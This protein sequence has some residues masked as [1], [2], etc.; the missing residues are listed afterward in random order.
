MIY[1]KTK[2]ICTI[3]PAVESVEKICELIDAG[4]DAARLNFSHG[5]HKIH[6]KY[7][8]NIREAAKLKGK[9]IA[10]IQD[11]PG[12]KIRV[13]RL[14][15]GYIDLV[16][17]WD[18]TIT[19]KEVIGNDQI[20][21]TNY[22]GLINDLD[23]GESILLDDGNLK[24]K[25]T[26]LDKENGEAVCEIINGGILKE[27]KGINLPETKLNLNPLTEKDLEHLRFGLENG[28]DFIAMSFVRV[29]E[30]ITHLRDLLRSDNIDKPII[31]KI[32]RPEAVENIDSIIEVS[33]VIMVARGDMGVEISTEEVP[34]IQKLIINKCNEKIKPVITATQM[35]ESMIHSPTPTRAEASDIANAI[36]DG[37]DC[38]MLSAETSTGEYP[39]ITVETMK[40]IILKTETEKKTKYFKEIFVEDSPENTLHTICNS[41]TEIATRVDAKAI[42]TITHNGKSPMLLSNH[43]PNAQIISAT[44]DVNIIRKCKLIW[45]VESIKIEKNLDYNATFAMIRESILKYNIL[46]KSDRIVLIAPMPFSDSESANM[47]QVTEV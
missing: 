26:S 25:V 10:I 34:L 4:M 41:A 33:D 7:I 21:S 3:G 36:F 43:R 27:K 15:K 5:T 46:N 39:V 13:G 47:I 40:K 11:L 2:I 31:A 8:E 14:E 17:G 1:K 23:I 32:E 38:V 6:K 29:A 24:L 35:L 20:I 42:I 12:P 45:G 30:D 19:T 18:I 9:L 37:T 44:H 16:A 28:I 22:P